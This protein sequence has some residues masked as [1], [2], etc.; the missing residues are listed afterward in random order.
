MKNK[1]KAFTLAVSL[2]FM[3]M[4]SSVI[5][6]DSVALYSDNQNKRVIAIDPVAMEIK[7]V[8]K[9]KVL[10]YPVDNMGG[11]F[12]FVSTRGA[13]SLDVINNAT[14]T[15]NNSI[16]MRHTPRSPA[17]RSLTGLALV[18]GGDEPFMT[19]IDVDTGQKLAVIEE[20][21]GPYAN[22][23]GGLASGHPFWVD[24]ERFLLL[25]RSARTLSLYNI[26]GT[27]LSTIDT[28]S[29]LH[30]VTRSK[31]KN[32]T[33][34]GS[35]EGSASSDAGVLKFE[36]VDGDLEFIDRVNTDP[37]GA[38][39]IDMVPGSAD[40]IYQGTNGGILYVIDGTS[41]ALINMVHVKS[42]A[43]HTRFAPA[44][45][46]AIITNHKADEI[47]IIDT[48]THSWVTDV[49]IPDG[50]NNSVAPGQKLQA[51]TTAV[52]GNHFYGMAS[53]NGVFYRMDLDTLEIDAELDIED[54]IGDGYYIQGTF[55]LALQD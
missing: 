35:L 16:G 36:I 55:I 14:L 6:S 18:A 10:P 40:V 44:K 52:K 45:G 5:A 32:S 38:H 21:K 12:S 48:S 11:Q 26:D 51:H 4:S 1:I 37:S 42:G 39:H 22:K 47:S 3:A 50:G 33:F 53:A 24:N 46:L 43:G 20:E 34:Y 19:V 8:I 7:E 41:M 28:E 9:T 30:H 2:P 25:N 27:L 23:G 17:Y 15:K 54:Q 49:A 31:S 29:S 13:K